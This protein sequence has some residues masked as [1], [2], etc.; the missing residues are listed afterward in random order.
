MSYL[1]FLGRFAHLFVQGSW[2]TLQLT[3][4]ATLLGLALGLA[5]ALGR[6]S[7]LAPLRWLAQVYIWVFRGTPLLVQLFLFHY[8][9]PQ[10][11]PSLVPAPFVS[12][13][14]VLSINA[15]AYLAEIIRA[16][17]LSIDKGQLEAACSLGMTR[18]QALRRVILPQTYRR[19]LPPVGNELI[20]LLKESSLVSTIAMVDLMRQA[21]QIYSATFRPFDALATA[22]LIYLLLTSVIAFIVERLEQRLG[23][24]GS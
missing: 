11:V 4:L 7:T 5:A 2:M 16:A 20:A 24:S 15:G 18:R 23:V 10:L 1:G 13:V 19:L 8:G 22:A 17:I 3:G 14:A 6:L 12:A 21:Q 9:L